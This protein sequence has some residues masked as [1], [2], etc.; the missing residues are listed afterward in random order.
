MAQV[1]PDNYL[2]F[3]ETYRGELERAR[4]ALTYRVREERPDARAAGEPND[5]VGAVLAPNHLARRERE[6]LRRLSTPSG[7]P[8]DFLG[9]WW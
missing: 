9:R 1:V 2:R 3:G 6:L 5:I 7:H 8:P 4:N